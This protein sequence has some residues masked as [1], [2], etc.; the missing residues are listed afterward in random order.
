[1]E[2]CDDGME[3]GCGERLLSMLVVRGPVLLV[4]RCRCDVDVLLLQFHRF[5]LVVAAV[6]L[7]CCCCSLTASHLLLLLCL[8]SVGG[9]GGGALGW[10]RRVSA[11]GSR[12]SCS[13]GGLLEHQRPPGGRPSDCEGGGWHVPLT[14]P[15]PPPSV[16]AL[17]VAS[18]SAVAGVVLGCTAV[19]S[20]PPPPP[21][22][23]HP[24]YPRTCGLRDSVAG[25]CGGVSG[26]AGAVCSGRGSVCPRLQLPDRGTTHVGTPKGPGQ[27]GRGRSCL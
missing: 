6:M 19:Y 27:R 9:G 1:M 25:P 22:C 3:A 8:C 11:V 20:D 23:M 14:S 17:P 21:H 2:G 16:S 10:L 12:K 4:S 26:G 7:M 5:S 24:S 13:G 15:S 18:T